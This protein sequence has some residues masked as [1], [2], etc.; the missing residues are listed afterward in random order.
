LSKVLGAACHTLMVDKVQEITFICPKSLFGNIYILLLQH[1][2]KGEGLLKL[3]QRRL[4]VNGT[5]GMPV[6]K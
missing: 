5:T 1:P 3:L 6:I 2:P 4:N